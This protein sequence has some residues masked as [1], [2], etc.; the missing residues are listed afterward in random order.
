MREEKPAERSRKEE[1]EEEEVEE[2][3]HKKNE[4]KK[5]KKKKNWRSSTNRRRST[6][7]TVQRNFAKISE[8]SAPFT[9]DPCHSR[10]PPLELPWYEAVSL[11]SSTFDLITLRNAPLDSRTS[12][13]RKTLR[14]STRHLPEMEKKLIEPLHSACRIESNFTR[15]AVDVPCLFKAGN[16]Q[17]TDDFSRKDNISIEMGRGTLAM[18]NIALKPSTMKPRNT[19]LE[20]ELFLYVYTAIFLTFSKSSSTATEIG[21]IVLIQKFVK[22]DS[23]R[24]TNCLELEKTSHLTYVYYNIEEQGLAINSGDA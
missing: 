19:D 9:I 15:Y 17:R 21:C 8:Q 5:R 13:H 20:V 11:L 22:H 6:S 16:P 24:D 3:Q 23:R 4:K 2:E 12:F 10:Q 7:T 18:R 1:E 14:T